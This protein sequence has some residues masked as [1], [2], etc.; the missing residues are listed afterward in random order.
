MSNGNQHLAMFTINEAA[1][2]FHGLSAY[3]IRQ[4]IKSGEL[5]CIRAGKKF[6]V[7]EQAIRDYI[8]QNAVFCGT[9]PSQGAPHR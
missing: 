2:R 9:V 7:C 6:L 5:P 8:L 4:L 3:R 1:E